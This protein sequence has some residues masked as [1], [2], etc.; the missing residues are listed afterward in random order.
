MSETGLGQIEQIT[1]DFDGVLADSAG[2]KTEAFKELYLDMGADV[3]DAMYQHHLKYPGV[4]RVDKIVWLEENIL[5]RTLTPEEL[6]AR[7]DKFGQLV[8]T[9][10]IASEEIPG[11]SGFLKATSAQIPLAVASATPLNELQRIV[12]AREMS[13]Y[14]DQV[15]GS[16]T[17]KAEAITEMLATHQIAPENAAMVGDAL[18]DFNAARET[19]VNFIGVLERDDTHPFI[20]GTTVIAD[21]TELTAA[22]RDVRN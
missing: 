11:A 10:V 18:S 17:S 2:I 1:F 20:A 5:H 4:P 12:K 16:P 22:L 21:L 3:A 9:K 13:G 7:A 14:F 19:G 8:E 15:Y 6:Q